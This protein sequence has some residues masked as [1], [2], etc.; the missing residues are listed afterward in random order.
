MSKSFASEN[1]KLS[2]FQIHW[3]AKMENLMNKSYPPS[4]CSLKIRSNARQSSRI[5]YSWAYNTKS[6]LQTHNCLGLFIM[7]L[8]IY[9][10]L[11][12]A[13]TAIGLPRWSISDSS[14]SMLLLIKDV[15][16]GIRALITDSKCYKQDQPIKLI[17]N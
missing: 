1:T 14:S 6:R 4:K 15:I 3:S 5:V 2:K 7:K 12:P 13:S 11:T 17:F 9:G 10:K 8:R 16:L